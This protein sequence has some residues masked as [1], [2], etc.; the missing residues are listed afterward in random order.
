MKMW[1]IRVVQT[2]N[3][4]GVENHEGG[5]ISFAFI[6]SLRYAG[7]ITEHVTDA[8]G[9]TISCFDIHGLGSQIWAEQNAE[10]MRSFGFNAVAAPSTR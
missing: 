2:M 7:V 3:D 1:V 4:D 10:R 9:L 6:D 8:R 5:V